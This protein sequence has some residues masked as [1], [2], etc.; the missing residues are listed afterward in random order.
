M[1]LLSSV[2]MHCDVSLFNSCVIS[3]PSM[4]IH[5]SIVMGKEDSEGGSGSDYLS[6]GHVQGHSQGSFEDHFGREGGNP[7]STPLYEVIRL[8][9]EQYCQNSSACSTLPFSRPRRLHFLFSTLAPMHWKFCLRSKGRG[10][11]LRTWR[12]ES[13]DMPYMGE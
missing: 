10:T 1:R 3:I 2:S 4:M 13:D 5:C 11:I 12:T 6:V 8:C 9:S 7:N